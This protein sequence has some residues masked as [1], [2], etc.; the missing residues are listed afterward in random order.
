MRRV[1]QVVVTSC[2]NVT[3]VES[4]RRNLEAML[5][6]PDGYPVT[7][8]TRQTCLLHIHRFNE[9]LDEISDGVRAVEGIAIDPTHIVDESVHFEEAT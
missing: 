4:V 2:G 8:P 5:T 7:E 9:H 6:S 3:L 1:A